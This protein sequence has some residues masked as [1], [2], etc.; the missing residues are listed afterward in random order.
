MERVFKLNKGPVQFLLHV[1]NGYVDELEV[2]PADFS[3]IDKD[4]VIYFIVK[5]SNLTVFSYAK[6]NCW[7]SK[8]YNRINFVFFVVGT[9][10]EEA[11]RR[12]SDW[13]QAII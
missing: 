4:F 13:R 5:K 8:A 2:F 12:N 7:I 11:N 3:I 9:L 10:V 1:V 6:S